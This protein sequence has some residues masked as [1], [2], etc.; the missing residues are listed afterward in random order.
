[1][2]DWRRL[3]ASPITAGV[4]AVGCVTAAMLAAPA[5]ISEALRER[6]LDQTLLVAS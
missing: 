5:S 1:M 2:T 3:L 6:A 4:L